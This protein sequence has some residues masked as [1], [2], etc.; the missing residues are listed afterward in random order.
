MTRRSRGSWL[1][2]FM[3][4]VGCHRGA[5]KPSTTDAPLGEPEARRVVVEVLNPGNEVGL[6]R[7]TTALLRQQPSLDVVF[8]GVKPDTVLARRKRNLIYVRRGD[9]TGV[10]A[11]MRAIGDADVVDLADPSRF[12]DLTVI[13]AGNLA[14]RTP[15]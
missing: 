5:S 6:A 15:P 4:L 1:A 12:V 14:A 9:T 10:G 8:F 13:P 11:V 3:L 7:T 2:A